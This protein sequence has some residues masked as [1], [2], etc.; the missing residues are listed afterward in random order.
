[1]NL[2]VGQQVMFGERPGA[3][4]LKVEAVGGGQAMSGWGEP[5]GP[6]P[7]RPR[8]FR[9]SGVQLPLC[10]GPMKEHPG[11]LRARHREGDGT[12]CSGP[13]MPSH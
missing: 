1:M 8:P 2:G 12:G 7:V 11:R 6:L 3:P 9:S 5:R 10:G 4:G 13:D